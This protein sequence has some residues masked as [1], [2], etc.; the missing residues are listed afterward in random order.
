MHIIKIAR[1]MLNEKNLPNYFWAKAV[2][3]IIYIMNQT[4]QQQFM[5]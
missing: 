5:A 2:A 3:T 1:A 4:P